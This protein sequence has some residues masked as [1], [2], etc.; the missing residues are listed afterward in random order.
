MIVLRRFL[1]WG[2]MSGRDHENGDRGLLMNLDEAG[3]D[4]DDLL[5]DVIVER[6]A[7]K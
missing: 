1:Q 2:I 3:E 4:I 6:L 7:L 5:S